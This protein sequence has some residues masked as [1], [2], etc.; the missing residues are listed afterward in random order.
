[1]KIH[2]GKF[3]TTRNFD[4]VLVVYSET[5]PEVD[6][7]RVRV[8]NKYFKI[9]SI[10]QNFPST[11]KKYDCHW[12]KFE[13]VPFDPEKLKSAL[14]LPSRSHIA[15]MVAQRLTLNPTEPYEKLKREIA[16]KFTCHD[17]GTLL[18]LI[19][20]EY[21]DQTET[22]DDVKDLRGERI[23]KSLRQF[24]EKM[25]KRNPPRFVGHRRRTG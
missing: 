23:K 25:R 14:P 7:D 22:P 13:E 16:E 9:T 11:G 19:R 1:M 24:N 8:D 6:I 15:Y 4:E 20:G 10:P 17:T 12:C 2:Q 5:P 21:E 18:P 3:K